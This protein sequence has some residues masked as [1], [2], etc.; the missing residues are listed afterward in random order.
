[1]NKPFQPTDFQRTLLAYLREHL[2]GLDDEQL[3]EIVVS[4]GLFSLMGKL[5]Q[6]KVP[7]PPNEKRAAM[8]PRPLPDHYRII[9]EP[10]DLHALENIYEVQ[11]WW[12]E[13]VELL[14]MVIRE[15]LK[16]MNR[17]GASKR[18]PTES[19]RS[20]NEVH[21]E[22]LD[23]LSREARAENPV[24][25]LLR[26]IEAGDALSLKFPK[27]LT[28]TLSP[29]Q[30][31]AMREIADREPHANDAQLVSKVISK[32]IEAMKGDGVVVPL[33][34]ARTKRARHKER[35]KD[36]SLEDRLRRKLTKFVDR[37]P[38]ALS[39]QEARTLLADL[40]TRPGR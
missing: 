5:L 24:V 27:T 16:S 11:P 19:T 29:E 36:V 34:A 20:E 3:F 2:P 39:K 1:M 38:D 28:V 13:P 23:K 8:A 21:Q 4:Q 37:H 9:L 30:Q 12:R 25:A 10:K 15:G 26:K 40:G 31:E 18:D 14:H 33:A 7:P 6:D 35:E 17:A 22:K 32:G